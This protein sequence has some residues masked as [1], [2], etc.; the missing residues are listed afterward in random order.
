MAV[1]A[2]ALRLCVAADAAGLDHRSGPP[3]G[4]SDLRAEPLQH[5]LPPVAHRAGHRGLCR[6]VR[7]EEDAVVWHRVDDP[8]RAGRDRLLVDAPPLMGDALSRAHARLRL[9]P[10]GP[11]LVSRRQRQFQPRAQSGVLVRQAQ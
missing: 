3:A 4:R 7:A 9:G 11:D 5:R 2:Q 8:H 6:S 10:S 1:L